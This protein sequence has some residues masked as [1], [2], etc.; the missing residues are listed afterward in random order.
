MSGKTTTWRALTSSGPLPPT[1]PVRP[2][3]LV[4][5]VH[6]W[7]KEAGG[8]K[9]DAG[10]SD[11][12]GESPLGDYCLSIAGRG[13]VSL[14]SRVARQAQPAHAFTPPPFPVSPVLS[15]VQATTRRWC[16]TVSRCA[17]RSSHRLAARTS[18][19]PAR[20]LARLG[21]TCATT[22]ST[23]TAPS[24]AWYAVVVVVLWVVVGCC[25]CCGL[26]WVVV[27]VGCCCCCCCAWVS[28]CLWVCAR[29]RW[30]A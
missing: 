7:G 10:I 15:W 19:P 12:F 8:G 21:A 16:A 27:V 17:R 2:G 14:G 24:V 1:P 9:K 28:V 5:C 29:A 6:V 30:V 3:A 20:P 13:C 22:A 18:A 23:A 25:C 11:C 26:L 4:T